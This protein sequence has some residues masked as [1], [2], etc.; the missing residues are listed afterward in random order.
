MRVSVEKMA[1]GLLLSDCAASLL[2]T[3]V[4]RNMPLMSA[5]L[6][7]IAASEFTKLVSERVGIGVSTVTLF[8][9]PTLDSIASHLTA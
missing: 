6:D 1:L 7:S 8:D 4:S 9:H 2:G 5:G 3:D